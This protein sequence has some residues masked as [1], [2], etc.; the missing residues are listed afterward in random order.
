M[1][2]E[3]IILN[4]KKKLAARLLTIPIEDLK[5]APKQTWYA[6]YIALL[7]IRLEPTAGKEFVAELRTF[8]NKNIKKSE[9]EL[10]ILGIIQFVEPTELDVPFNQHLWHKTLINDVRAIFL[11]QFPSVNYYDDDDITAYWLNRQSARRSER[12]KIRVAFVVHSNITC[13]KVLPLYEA[14]KQHEDFEPY[15]VIHP[16]FDYR[17]GD[18]AWKYF[19]LRYPDGEIYDYLSLMDIRKLK[20]DYVFF[21]N[22]YVRHRPFP[23]LRIGDMLTFTKICMVS[24]GASLA[25]VFPERLFNEYPHVYKNLYALFA[26][27]ESVKTMAHEQFAQDETFKYRHVEFL[28]YPALKTYYRMEKEP[29]KATRI[30]WTPRWLVDDTWGGSHFLEYKDK[31]NALRGKY[32]ERVELYFRPH[33]NLFNELLTKNLMTREEIL[34]YKKSLKANGIIQQNRLADMY[35]SIRGVDIFLADY[36]SILICFFLTGRPIIYCELPNA[37]PFPE[38]AEMFAAMYTARSWE[39]V[40]FYLAELIAGNDP[41][42]EKRQAIAQ[43]IYETHKDAAERIVDWLMQDFF[44]PPLSKGGHAEPTV[45]AAARHFD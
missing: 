41:L 14:M 8:Y 32:G 44:A 33:M 36:S 5:T 27:C 31:F 45:A 40:E 38:Y 2:P 22:P 15:I 21:T 7:P 17:N 6:E 39:E 3:E 35:E 16:D 19:F 12:R 11:N 9:R 43:K 1:E 30:L 4:K 10:A 18:A 23:S 24:Y 20:P 34:A 13:D 37:V 29:S 26:S 42:F 28:G 25:Y